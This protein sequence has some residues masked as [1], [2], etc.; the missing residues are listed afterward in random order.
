MS[1]SLYLVLS[2]LLIT[3]LAASPGNITIAIIGTNDIH[4]AAFPAQLVRSDNMSQ[5]Y[6]YGGLQ[7]MGRLIQIVQSEYDGNVLYLDGGDQFQGGI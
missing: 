7:Y 5:Q 3:T 4:G 6:L 2:F 1:L